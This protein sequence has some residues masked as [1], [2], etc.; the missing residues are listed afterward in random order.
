[1][2]II[3]KYK[4]MGEKKWNGGEILLKHRGIDVPAFIICNSLFFFPVA[5]FF[6]YYN[7]KFKNFFGICRVWLDIQRDV[8]L[9]VKGEKKIKCLTFGKF[10]KKFWTYIGHL[11]IE[12]LWFF[13]LMLFF[14]IKGNIKAFLMFIKNQKV[15]NIQLTNLLS[16]L[17]VLDVVIEIFCILCNI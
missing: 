7:L 17:L 8:N 10:S 4:T 6:F 14:P 12:K 1:M 3:Y 5:F 16:R 13:F 15:Q 2:Y 11:C 9:Y